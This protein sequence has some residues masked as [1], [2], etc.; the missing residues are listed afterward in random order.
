MNNTNKN[1]TTLYSSLLPIALLLLLILGAGYFLLRDEFNLEKVL[2]NEPEVRRLEGFPTVVNTDQNIDKQRA[3]IK[4]QD[5]LDNFLKTV[6]PSGNLKLTENIDFDKEYLIG[7]TTK[8]LE[9]DGTQ[10]KVRKLYE[11][12]E[13]NTLLVS[14][15]QTEPGL[16]C[17]TTQQTN[18]P[19][20]IVAISKTDHK[21]TFEVL[22]E[23]KACE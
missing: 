5:E 12:K 21:V 3:F 8:T 20:D 10:I 11:D 1:G 17:V 19:V 15:K 16:N 13:D 14:L 18:L 6:D 2:S 7:V 23:Q 22:K 4:T 9:S